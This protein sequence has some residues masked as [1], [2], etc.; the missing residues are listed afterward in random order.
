MNKL[1]EK[2]LC[3]VLLLMRNNTERLLNLALILI[4]I[5][6]NKILFTWDIF[7][8]VGSFGCDITSCHS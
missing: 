2:I 3:I 6:S 8:L 1:N 4:I 5:I 7:I